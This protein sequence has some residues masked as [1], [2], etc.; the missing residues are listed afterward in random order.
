M[1][2][3]QSALAVVKGTLVLTAYVVLAIVVYVNIEPWDAVDALCFAMMTCSTVGYGD[4]SPTP[5]FGPRT[6]TIFMI[7]FGIVVVF[8]VA[9]NAISPLIEPLTR[10]GREQLERMF[11]QIAVD[12]DGNG[13][14]D[15]KVPRNA[16]IY[17]AKNLLPS[18]ALNLVVQIVSAA[19][20]CAIEGWDF[21][22]AL[23]HCLVTGTTVGYG[24]QTI[25]TDGGKLWASVHMLVAVAMIAELIST[26]GTLSEKRSANLARVAQLERRFDADLV[27]KLMTTAKEL[28]PDVQRDGEGLT[29]LEVRTRRAHSTRTHTTRAHVHGHVHAHVHVHVAHTTQAY[30]TCG[31]HVAHTTQ[32]YVYVCGPRDACPH[33]WQFVLANLVTLQIV[34]MDRVQPFIL[35]FRKL[36]VTNDGR[37]GPADLKLA[38]AIDGDAKKRLDDATHTSVRDE[39]ASVTASAA[40]PPSVLSATTTRLAT[41]SA[42]GAVMTKVWPE[43]DANAS[44]RQLQLEAD[45]ATLSAK[46]AAI[47]ASAKRP[48]G[49]QHHEHHERHDTHHDDRMPPRF[50]VEGSNATCHHGH[51][52]SA[53]GCGVRSART[54]VPRSAGTS[55]PPT[56]VPATSYSMSPTSCSVPAMRTAPHLPSHLPPMPLARPLTFSERVKA[57]QATNGAA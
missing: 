15:Y 44:L 56:P 11:P 41:I 23:Y 26:F 4:I 39:P 35:R 42:A 47:E 40:V 57:A 28:R 22:S 17:Y 55:V 25:V 9:G 49:G 3:S 46:V 16:P 38:S 52:R 53:V 37:L 31:P 33:A 10:R 8:P 13:G 20:F 5:T 2:L 24:D 50:D 18:V 14:A 54:S 32:T 30:A 6:F 27:D 1:R 12:I 36:D 45:V 51:G 29:E 19:I 34:D 48:S 7:L 43:P 21:G